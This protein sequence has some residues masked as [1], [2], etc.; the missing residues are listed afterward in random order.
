MM[1]RLYSK[2]KLLFL[3]GNGSRSFSVDGKSISGKSDD[4]QQYKQP[5]DAP[6]VVCF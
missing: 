4:W 1:M 6:P 3:A 2:E 5:C